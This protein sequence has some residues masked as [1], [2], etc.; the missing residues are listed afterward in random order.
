[1]GSCADQQGCWLLSTQAPIIDLCA[2]GLFVN[3]P[4]GA[5]T[6][7]DRSFETK[8]K[9]THGEL[10]LNLNLIIDMM[11]F[12]LVALLGLMPLIVIHWTDRGARMGPPYANSRINQRMRQAATTIKTS[13]LI[14]AA[15]WLANFQIIV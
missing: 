3:P 5:W 15:D 12:L 7:L 6:G 8:G 2:P 14:F 4:A 9:N 11:E 1:M 10:Q 13:L